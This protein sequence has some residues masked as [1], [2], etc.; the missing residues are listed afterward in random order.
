MW[1]FGMYDHYIARVWSYLPNNRL[2]CDLSTRLTAAREAAE[3]D[4]LL[5][6]DRADM[7]TR[8]SVALL[9]VRLSR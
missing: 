8:E 1:S 4:C 6:E 9:E 7:A 2:G 5:A 3:R